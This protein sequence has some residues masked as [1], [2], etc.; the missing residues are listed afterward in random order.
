MVFN[1]EVLRYFGGAIGFVALIHKSI[2]EEI[3][4]MW[5][6]IGQGLGWIN[7]KI[8]MGAVFFTILFPIAIITRLFGR[9]TLM[10][11]DMPR[12]TFYTKRYHTY[13]PKDLKN[14]W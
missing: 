7:S 9:D 4:W 3:V 11:K 13:T 5:E 2:A 12:D 6:K 8:I 1:V 14:I 10:L